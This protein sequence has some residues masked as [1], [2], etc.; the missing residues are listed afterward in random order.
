M[1]QVFLHNDF[2]NS[3]SFPDVVPVNLK[4]RIRLWVQ[5]HKLGYGS[6]IALVLEL[7]Y[8]LLVF[9]AMALLVSRI[10]TEVIM[11][12]IGLHICIVIFILNL[13]Q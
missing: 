2:L 3:P 4:D 8:N 5:A 11:C 10:I 1:E 7:A 13:I 6:A 9:Y 12:C